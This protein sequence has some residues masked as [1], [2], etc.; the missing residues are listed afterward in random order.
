M[1]RR[2]PEG[3]RRKMKNTT[4]AETASEKRCLKF[5]P[6]SVVARNKKRGNTVVR[7]RWAPKQGRTL[8]ECQ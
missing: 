5:K 1:L 6:F 3:F 2:W 7:F 4:E 8:G